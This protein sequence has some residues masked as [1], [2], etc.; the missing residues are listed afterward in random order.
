MMDAPFSC[1][2][3]FT[4]AAS[5]MLR[6]HLVYSHPIS[7]Q[8]VRESAEVRAAQRYGMCGHDAPGGLQRFTGTARG[9]ASFFNV[10]LRTLLQFP[11]PALFEGFK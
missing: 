2:G 9:L 11:V 4:N 6:L 3:L 1:P 8:E 5:T 7:I 10:R